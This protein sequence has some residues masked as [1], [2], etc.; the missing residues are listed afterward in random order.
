M[1]NVVR[2]ISFRIYCS[3]L[4]TDEDKLLLEEPEGNV[5]VHI[6]HTKDFRFVTVNVFSTTY[7]KVQV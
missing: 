7:S 6:R 2:F 1:N 5:C 3:I 4:G